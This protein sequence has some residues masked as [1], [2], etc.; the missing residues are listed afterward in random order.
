MPGRGGTES[1][2]DYQ[3]YDQGANSA[4][5]PNEFGTEFEPQPK[6]QAAAEEGEE[7][8]GDDGE[9]EEEEEDE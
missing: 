4:A 8:E 3:D 1:A 6:L 5:G 9:G 2:A 7:E